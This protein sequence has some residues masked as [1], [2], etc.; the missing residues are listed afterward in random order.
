LDTFDRRRYLESGL[1]PP[2]VLRCGRP[3]WWQ[4]V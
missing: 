1:L 3:G 4:W 2:P